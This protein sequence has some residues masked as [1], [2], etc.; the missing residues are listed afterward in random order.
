MDTETKSKLLG[1]PI[2]NNMPVRADAGETLL[3]GRQEQAIFDLRPRMIHL[4]NLRG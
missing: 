2:A 1:Y 3:G 4:A